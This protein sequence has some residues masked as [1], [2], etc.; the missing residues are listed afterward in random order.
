MSHIHILFYHAY[1]SKQHNQPAYYI[2]NVKTSYM[3]DFN[4]VFWDAENAKNVAGNCRF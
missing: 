3:L 2:N 1:Y 4:E